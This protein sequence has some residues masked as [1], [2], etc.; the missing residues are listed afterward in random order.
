MLKI[1][2]NKRELVIA[3]DVINLTNRGGKGQN[4]FNANK[5][6]LRKGEEIISIENVGEEICLY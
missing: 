2:T 6:P 4:I 1:I 5:T 3:E